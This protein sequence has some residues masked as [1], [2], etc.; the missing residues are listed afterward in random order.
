MEARCSLKESLQTGNI[1]PIEAW[2]MQLTF[3]SPVSQKHNV[4]LLSYWLFCYYYH[5]CFVTI[6]ITV[7][8]SLSLLFCYPYPFFKCYHDYF[9]VIIITLSSLH[10]LFCYPQPYYFVIFIITILLSV[11][12]LFRYHSLLFCY[13]YL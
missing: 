2:N 9:A 13:H 8:L 1:H 10:L 11:S 4:I 12:L 6:I 7:L 5:Y 3:H